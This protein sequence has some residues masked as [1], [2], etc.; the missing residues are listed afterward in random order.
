MKKT[1][2]LLLITV[3]A[4]AFDGTLDKD[5]FEY[6]INSFTDWVLVIMIISILLSIAWANS[7]KDDRDKNTP[8]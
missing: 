2:T 3:L 1:F 8:K 6:K 5:I 4:V 7:T